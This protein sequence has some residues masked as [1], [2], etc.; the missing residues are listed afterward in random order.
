MMILRFIQQVEVETSRQ[1]VDVPL[2][3]IGPVSVPII[4]T[5]VVVARAWFQC[6]R[7]GI[8]AF[9]QELGSPMTPPPCPQGCD[10]EPIT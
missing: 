8:I 7:C 4:G 2:A 3:G 1:P 5:T 6:D 10:T 9:I